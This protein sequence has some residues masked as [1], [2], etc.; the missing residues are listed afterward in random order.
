MVDKGG[1][2]LLIQCLDEKLADDAINWK[3]MERLISSIFV[4]ACEDR[5]CN[6]LRK[7]NTIKRLVDAVVRAF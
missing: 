5:N 2:T 4:L 3:I 6:T 7:E 1:L